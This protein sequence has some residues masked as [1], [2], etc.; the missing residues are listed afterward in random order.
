MRKFIR[1]VVD[2]IA[3]FYRDDGWAISSH[4]ALSGLTSIFPFLI[5][6]TTLAGFFGSKA[7]ADKAASLIFGAWPPSVVGPLAREIHDVLTE[8]RGGLLTLSAALALYFASSGVEALRIG[9]NRAYNSRE[10]RA[11]WVLRLESI[12]YVFVGAL[13]LLALAFLLVLGPLIW[14]LALRVAPALH[15][16]SGSVAFWRYAISTLILVAAL[17]IAHVFLPAGRRRFFD[18]APGVALTFAAWLIFALAFGAYL[19]QFAHNYVS[20]YAGLASVMIAIVFLYS[21]AA[22]FVF[23]GEFNAAILRSRAMRRGFDQRA[24]KASAPDKQTA[25]EKASSRRSEL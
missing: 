3:C 6:V 22:I 12:A 10:G 5:F 16:L 18:I 25:E 11:W 24:A 1:L 4:I 9:L 23:G 2:A 19:S 21:T 8:P 14:A 13:A 7:L 17:V 20:T 15:E